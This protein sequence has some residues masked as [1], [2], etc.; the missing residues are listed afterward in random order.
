MFLFLFVLFLFLFV[1]FLFLFV[2]FFFV[3]F[4]SFFVRFGFGFG[5]VLVLRSGVSPKGWFRM[6]RAYVSIADRSWKASM[7]LMNLKW[8]EGW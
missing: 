8:V 4:V 7:G 1:L 6:F 2:L 5:P 3:R